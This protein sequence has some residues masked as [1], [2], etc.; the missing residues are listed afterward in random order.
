MPTDRAL[1]LRRF[2]YSES[3]LVVRALSREHG[4]VH[5]LARGAYRMHSRY[6]GVLDLFDELELEWR[7][8]PRR[9]LAEL[10]RG[11]VTRRRRALR[12]DLP[13]YRAA[14]AM[15]EL[16]DL[17]SRPGR[18][19]PELYELLSACLD[20]L[21]DADRPPDAALVVFELGFL[22]NH[23]LAPALARCAACDRNAPP[24][25][26]DRSRA[27]F[28]AGSGGRLCASCAEE[29]RAAGRRVG[30]MP[31]DVLQD[32]EA[33]LVDLRAHRLP[34]EDA[35]TDP[36]RL[37]ALRDLAERFLDYHL[38]STPKASRAFLATPN[39]NAKP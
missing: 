30:T 11:D 33:L 5:L 37:V 29:S 12:E 20:R 26:T 7:Q 36:D 35:I 6:F 4:R 38:D 10:R 34:P 24:T 3:S 22:Q 1:V 13:R 25:S 23:G 31:I 2:P 15:L 27:H 14:V 28:S 18:P 39:R 9:E 19:D 17:G 21:G 32:G 16:A 8:S